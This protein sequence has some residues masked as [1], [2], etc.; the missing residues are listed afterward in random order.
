MKNTIRL[1]ALIA[2]VLFAW[3]IAADRL[4]PFTG[5]ARIKT[6]VV[7]IVPQVSGY[8]D[9][10]AFTNERITDAG[11]VLATIDKRSFQFAV[12][13]A[14]ADVER[15]SQDV[16]ASSAEVTIAESNLSRAKTDLDNVRVQTDRIFDLEDKGLV[17]IARGDDA[18]SQLAAAESSL[19]G[20]EADLL[21]AQ[22]ELGDEGA[23][24][25]QLRAAQ[26]Q[27]GQAQLNLEWTDLHAPTRGFVTDVVI[28]P[29]SYVK[30]GQPAMTFVSLEGLWVEAYLTENNISRIKPGDPVELVLDS[31]PGRIVKGEVTSFS[32]AASSGADAKAGQL[33][34]IPRVSGWMRDP[35]RFPV[36]ITLPGYEHG[37]EKGDLRMMVNGQVD[38][39]VY[40]GSNPILNA[41]GAF[42]I[43]LLSYLSYLY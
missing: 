34:S 11:E 7:P 20:A 41:I 31:H 4:T 37:N 35:Q 38:V 6:V 43:R 22:E 12:E 23:D 26:A 15:T 10:V 39:I 24:N 25:P 29:G 1:T 42:Y 33:Q 28:G 2:L 40:T 27:L 8:V 17:P 19:A 3:Y 21:R 36:R 5:N 16:G 13:E 14:Q 32:G 18:R 9:T 30:A